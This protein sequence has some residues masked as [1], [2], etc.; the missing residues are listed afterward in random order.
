MFNKNGSGNAY[1]LSSVHLFIV[2]KNKSAQYCEKWYY[3]SQFG[4]KKTHTHGS[5]NAYFLRPVALHLFIGDVQPDVH[6]WHLLQEVLNVMTAH[7][8]ASHCSSATTVPIQY[9]FPRSLP[10]LSQRRTDKQMSSATM[11]KC[12]DL[13]KYAFLDPWLL[14]FFF[15]VLVSTTTSQNIR[16]FFNTL[17]RYLGNQNHIQPIN[18]A[19][20][21]TL[22]LWMIIFERKICVIAGTRTTD[23]QFSVLAP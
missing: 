4:E 20:K 13:R 9:L 12:T 2:A 15:L 19:F 23:L 6:S 16:H 1:F 8:N 5:G 3:I 7:G 11:D 22:D 17:Y 10:C 18:H 14:D 21:M